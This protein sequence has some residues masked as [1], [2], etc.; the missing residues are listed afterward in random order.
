MGYLRGTKI[1][2]H[3][4]IQSLEREETVGDRKVLGKLM[5]RELYFYQAWY[6]ILFHSH[7]LGI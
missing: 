2:Y 1:G 3:C 4:K 5:A 6:L 7:F